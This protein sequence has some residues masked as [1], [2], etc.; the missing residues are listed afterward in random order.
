MKDCD[1]AIDCNGRREFLVKAA[2]M[3]GGLV[4]SLSGAG[5][6]LGESLADVTVTIDEKS[7]LGKV[8]GSTLVDS[9]AGQIIIVRTGETTFVAFSAVCTHKRGIVKYDA[10]NNRFECPK[11]HSIFDAAT[12]NPIDGPADDPLARYPAKG[13]ATSVT[14]TVG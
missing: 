14:V 11:H 8:G 12:G 9:T 6:V 5:S 4:L 13:T 3:A 2:V 10:A 7:P 1:K